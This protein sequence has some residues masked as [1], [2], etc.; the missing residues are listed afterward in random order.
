MPTDQPPSPHEADPSDPAATAASDGNITAA[1]DGNGTAAPDHTGT[2]ATHSGRHAAPEPE[3]ERHDEPE[4]APAPPTLAAHALGLRTRHGWVFRDVDLEIRRGSV[5]ALVAPAGSGR[6][7]LL[8]ALTGRMRTTHG[9]VVFPGAAETEPRTL[10]ARTAVAR[11][12][13][14]IVP[15]DRHTVSEAITERCLIDGVAPRDG[16]GAFAAACTRLGLDIADRDRL[17][18]ELPA[19][20]R[21]VLTLALA[22]VRPADVIVIDDTDSGVTREQEHEIYR[23]A[24]SLAGTGCAVIATTSRREGVPD[25][26][27][28]VSIP[29]RPD[30]AA[31][32]YGPA[33]ADRRTPGAA[34][35][36]DPHASTDTGSDT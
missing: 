7:S 5:T 28:T 30:D 10:R 16:R 26:V 4:P 24:R 11:V 27:A 32:A 29:E 1:S 23:A 17:V 3:T 6:S 2:T 18:E 34:P 35:A 14:L 8:L 22:A 21:T 31:P 12:S 15:E 33:D 20:K 19:W 9:A 25:G 36:S 13:D